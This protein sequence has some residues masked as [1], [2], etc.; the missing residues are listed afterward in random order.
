MKTT[1]VTKALRE[2]LFDLF[3][4]TP[5]RQVYSDARK[6]GAA[7]G[8]K[9]VGLKLTD[10]QMD[11]VRHQME[12][13]GFTH[14]YSR[15]NAQGNWTTG[16]RFCYSPPKKTEQ[17]AVSSGIE[18]KVINREK[19]QPVCM[20]CSWEQFEQVRPI[21]EAHRL[22]VVAID[23]IPGH[24]YLVNNLSSVPGHIS[25]YKRSTDYGRTVVDEWDLEL[26]LHYCGIDT[27]TTKVMSTP[28]MYEVHL[29]DIMKIHDIACDAWK[30]V[31]TESCISKVHKLKLTHTFFQSDVDKMFKAATKKQIPV[32]EQVFGK[33][34]EKIEWDKIKTG[35]KVR[36]KY[37]GQ[38]CSGWRWD[39]D[40]TREVDV[41]FFGTEHYIRENGTF[42][43]QSLFKNQLTK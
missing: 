3:R 34:V 2:V 29:R 31:I 30:E 19:F 35:S 36:I 5:Q 6:D 21:L 26:F 43:K 9:F 40:E 32:L 41:V 13:R 23:Y 12:L 22:E 20:K 16:T 25:N 33:Q 1:S 24:D 15:T 14:H 42:G 4:Y 38:H 18:N 7:V 39:L 28:K 11:D 8:V 37:S 17:S 27:K 10:D